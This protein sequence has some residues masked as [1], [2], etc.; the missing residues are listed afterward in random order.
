M[1]QL[2]A[3]LLTILFVIAGCSGAA[4]SLTP[5]PSATVDSSAPIVSGSVHAGPVCP[6]ERPGDS[7][8][9]PRAVDGAVLVIERASGGEVARATSGVDGTFSVH[10]PPGDYRI[11]PQPVSGLLGTAQP[12]TLTVAADGTTS[13]SRIDISYD[14][15]IR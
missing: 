10:L 11:V 15:G 8:C 6:V 13:P 5:P 9:A 3:A 4:A 2:T 14:T 12:M 1:R 7:S